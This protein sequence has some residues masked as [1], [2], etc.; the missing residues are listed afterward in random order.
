[1]ERGEEGD[2]SEVKEVYLMFILKSILKGVLISQ[3]RIIITQL[4]A[5]PLPSSITLRLISQFPHN[6]TNSPSL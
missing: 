2:D 5:P 1:M 6:S 4:L 3:I